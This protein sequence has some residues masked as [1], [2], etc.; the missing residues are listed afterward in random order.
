MNNT[1]A[2]KRAP[3]KNAAILNLLVNKPRLNI[4]S[5]SLQLNPRKN[6][7]KQRVENAI[8]EAT[9]VS[10]SGFPQLKAII[11]KIEIIIPS[12]ATDLKSSLLNIFSLLPLGF[13]L[14]KLLLLFSI[15]IAIA[16][17]LSVNRFIKSRCTAA[18]GIGKLTIAAYTTA[19]IADRF[20]DNKN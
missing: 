15:P 6:L 16:G 11:V 14:S 8:V 5:L 18:K 1:D 7:A 3:A 17:I 2:S 9:L 10:I 19:I 20:P 13:S 12:N 4:D